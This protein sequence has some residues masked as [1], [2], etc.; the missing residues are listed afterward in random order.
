M[1]GLFVRNAFLA[2]F[3]F[4]TISLISQDPVNPGDKRFKPFVGVTYNWHSMEDSYNNE[5]EWATRP[6]QFPGMEAG[7][8]LEPKSKEGW[9]LEYRNSFLFELALYGIADLTQNP[10][11]G[12]SIMQ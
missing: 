8:L 1:K 7:F 5:G 11:N 6:S 3:L 12:S 9:S 10:Y 4:I 2:T